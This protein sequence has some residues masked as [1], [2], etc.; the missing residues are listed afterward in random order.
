MLK[1]SISVL[2]AVLMMVSVLT[3]GIVTAGATDYSGV[4]TDS[5]KLYFDANS[6]GWDMTDAK[7]AFYAFPLSDDVGAAYKGWGGK[8]LQGSD[9]DKD[10]IWEFAPTQWKLEDGVQYKIIFAKADKTNAWVAQT[11]DLY[12][13]TTCMGHVAYCNGTVYENPAD[14]SKTAL[15]AVFDGMDPASFGPVLQV[16]SIGNVV[17]TCPEQGKTPYDI[18]VDFISV[19]NSETGTTVLDNA[20]KYVVTPGTKTEQKMIDDIGKDLGLS[21]DDVEKAFTEN[22]VATVWT[23][24]DSTLP[25][26]GETP[27]EAPTE[28]PTEPHIHTPGEPV[29]ENE[30]PATCKAEGSYDEVVYCTECQEEISREHKTIDK[31]AHT[32]GE[33]VRENEVTVTCL[34][35]GS[36]DEVVYCTECGEE[37]SRTHWDVAH[38]GHNIIHAVEIPA[39]AT[40]DGIRSHYECTSCGKYFSDATGTVEVD[41]ADYIIKAEHKRGDANRDG[42]VDVLDATIIQRVLAEYEV[43]NYDEIAADADLDGIV[44]M[45]DVTLIQRIDAQMTTFEAWDEAHKAA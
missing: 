44:D 3:V 22:E 20:R 35:D 11:Y 27:T 28:A 41:P 9:A 21:K 34:V 12:F 6:T 15:A 32:P 18:F 4:T 43:E 10:G 2:L 24:A 13:D 5:G 29:R 30:V 23:A 26:G 45:I 16:S 38:P 1:K 7:I 42:V 37:I 31:L 36:Y 40:E 17:G 33:P 25:A 19:V 8:R 14:S 39:T